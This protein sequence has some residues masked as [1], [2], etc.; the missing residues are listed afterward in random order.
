MRFVSMLG[1]CLVLVSPSASWAAGAQT[2]A[3]LNDGEGV[4]FA[5]SEGPDGFE[6]KDVRRRLSRSI[7]LGLDRDHVAYSSSEAYETPSGTVG[8]SF[9][10]GLGDRRSSFASSLMLG[11]GAAKSIEAGGR[12]DRDRISA[13]GRGSSPRRLIGWATAEMTPPPWP[14]GWPRR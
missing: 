4:S 13:H 7:A 5:R 9:H 3:E 2:Q 12:V 10:L 1:V 6:R 8:S 11:R 14:Q